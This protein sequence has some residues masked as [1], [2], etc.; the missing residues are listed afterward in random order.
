MSVPFFAGRAEPESTNGGESPDPVTTADSS[1]TWDVE[2]SPV[3]GTLYA[4]ASINTFILFGGTGWG[5][6]GVI[7]Y[8]TRDHKGKDTVH[9]VGQSGIDGYVDYI[10]SNNVDSVTFGW[11][12]EGDSYCFCR[13]NFEIWA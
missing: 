5:G 13:L 1:W 6:G 3:S 7:E 8:R 11:I 9:H 12:S 4:K 2:F 10:W